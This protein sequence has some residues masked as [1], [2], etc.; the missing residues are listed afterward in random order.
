MQ[1]KFSFILLRVQ[2]EAQKLHRDVSNSMETQ[3]KASSVTSHNRYEHVVEAHPYM[4]A[5]CYGVCFAAD[6]C[7]AQVKTSELKKTAHL[8]DEGGVIAAS[9]RADHVNVWCFRIHADVGHHKVQWGP[10]AQ[11]SI[12]V[13]EVVLQVGVSGQCNLLLQSPAS[14][15]RLQHAGHKWI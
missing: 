2:N 10:N 14:C 5:G 11:H 1:A 9:D 8:V 7:W 3:A 12:Q 6:T 15:V 4:L 13:G